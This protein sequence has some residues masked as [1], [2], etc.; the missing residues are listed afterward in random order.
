MAN[1][2]TAQVIDFYSQLPEEYLGCPDDCWSCHG[3]KAFR[4]K[5]SA[6]IYRRFWTPFRWLFKAILFFRSI[7]R[8]TRSLFSDEKPSTDVYLGAHTL[9]FFKDKNRGLF[10][11]HRVFELLR[12][13]HPA[14]DPASVKV[15]SLGCRSEIELYYYWLFFGFSWKNM[16]GVDIVSLSPKIELAD[17]SERLPFADNSF[18]MILASH[19]LEK[20]K[21]PVRTRDEI[22][23]VVKPNGRI[24]ICGNNRTSKQA[25]STYPYKGQNIPSSY[26]REG[27]YSF[28]GL[29]QIPV[30]DIE[31]MDAYNGHGFQIIF[32]VRKSARSLS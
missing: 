16:T 27:V 10:G 9:E 23:R 28:V 13:F 3:K 21:D 20:S 8:P 19:C 17:F 22:L 18:D 29:Y 26:F 12:N 6:A 2:A 5:W 14:V 7:G 32:K 1:N 25:V 11:Y 4:A 30:E 31:H 24:L 15:L